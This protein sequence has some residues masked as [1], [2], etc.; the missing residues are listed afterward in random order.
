MRYPQP[1]LSTQTHAMVLIPPQHLFHLLEPLKRSDEK[2]GGPNSAAGA[3]RVTR[4]SA[5]MEAGPSWFSKPGHEKS[6]EARE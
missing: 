5:P 4:L 1:S 6:K 3:L 2:H